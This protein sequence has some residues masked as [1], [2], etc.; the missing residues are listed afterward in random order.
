MSF[1]TD[2]SGDRDYNTGHQQDTGDKY[3]DPQQA[4]G[5]HMHRS[6]YLQRV[7][8]H[9]ESGGLDYSG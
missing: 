1:A 5:C 2:V 8:L 9:K 7:C 3:G 6:A 4:C